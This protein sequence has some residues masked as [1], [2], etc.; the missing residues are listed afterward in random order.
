MAESPFTPAKGFLYM[1]IGSEPA[2]L[3]GVIHGG[4]KFP[5]I[6]PQPWPLT[7]DTAD[8]SSFDDRCTLGL[9]GIFSVDKETSQ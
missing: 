7:A 8:F 6:N 4:V 1:D 2:T 9:L 3:G 5:F